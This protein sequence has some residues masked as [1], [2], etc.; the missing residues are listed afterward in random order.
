[1]GNAQSL[2]DTAQVSWI[3]PAAQFFVDGPVAITADQDAGAIA[4][5][6][7]RH[8]VLAAQVSQQDGIAVQNLLR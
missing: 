5:P 6:R 3:L 2:E 4:L 1:M 8:A 7:N